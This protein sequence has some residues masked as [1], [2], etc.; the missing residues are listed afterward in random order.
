MIRLSESFHSC[1][2]ST[3]DPMDWG[4]RYK[5][6]A[7]KLYTGNDAVKTSLQTNFGWI[8]SLWKEVIFSDMASEQLE[9]SQ[10]SQLTPRNNWMLI[11]VT[12]F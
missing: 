9:K 7:F 11:C 6:S 4:Y 10:Q 12:Q 1:T 3:K 5:H 8:I 2:F